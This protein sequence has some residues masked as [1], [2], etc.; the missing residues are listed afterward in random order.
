MT[1]SDKTEKPSPKRIADAREKGQVVRSPD[2][3]GGLVLALGSLMLALGGAFWSNSLMQVTTHVL[4]QMQRT[5][6]MTS[7][8]W[9][10]T[11]M[12]VGSVM[13]SLVVPIGVALMVAGVGAHLAVTGMLY[14]TQPLMPDISKLNPM[15]GFQRLFNKDKLVELGKSLLKFGLLAAVLYGVVVSG[16]E[17]LSTWYQLPLA[18]VLSQGLWPQITTLMVWASA[19][20]MVVGVIDWRWNAWQYEKKLMMSRQDLIDERKNQDGDPKMKARQRR[21]G[22]QLVEK[23]QLSSVPKADVIINNPTHFSVAIQ[24][25]PDLGPAPRV[26]AKGQDFFALKIRET[27]KQH[28]VPMVENKP[29]A[30]SLYKTVDVDQMI[31]PDLFVA[32]AEV[33]AY[34][35]AQNKGRKR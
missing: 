31:P 17:K 10:Y 13:V 18:T 19:A 32:V 35:Y 4:R 6:P 2:L 30:Q 21:M 25:D 33:L 27:A 8:Q 7:S 34:V 15:T 24:Y 29:L 12:D 3:T 23:R 20:F 28:G 14:T 1:G 5:T 26:I 9:V 16:S 11:M 22:R